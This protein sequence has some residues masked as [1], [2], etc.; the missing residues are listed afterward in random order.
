MSVVYAWGQLETG[1]L[2]QPGAAGGQGPDPV[3]A[4]AGAIGSIVDAISGKAAKEE[5]AAKAAAAAAQAQLQAAQL[6]GQTPLSPYQVPAAPKP[7]WVPGVPNWVLLGGAG[8]VAYFLLRK[9][10]R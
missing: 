10:R 9:K 1:Q 4:I 2:A 8:A 3:A 5:R 6:A 7:Q